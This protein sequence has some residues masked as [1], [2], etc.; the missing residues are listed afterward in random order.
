MSAA[1]ESTL[2]EL[3]Q[4]AAANNA[5]MAKLT[6]LI[7][8]LGPKLG[9]ANAGVG[10]SASGLIAAFNPLSLVVKGITGTFNILSNLLGSLGNIIGSTVGSFQKF[11]AMTTTGTMK[12]S[13]LSKIIGD[14]VT[15][16]PVF[17]SI[18]GSVVGVFT[19]LIQYSEQLLV[20]YRN[21]SDVGASFGGNLFEMAQTAYNS[22]LTLDEF[23]NIIKQNS[24]ILTAIGPG[25]DAGFRKFGEINRLLIGPGSP[26]SRAILSLGV[27]ASES[28]EMLATYINIHGSLNRES[29]R[30]NNVVAASVSNMIKEID[31][32]AK[33]TGQSRKD[34]EK[35]LASESLNSQFKM[36]LR[37]LD[38]QQVDTAML[39]VSKALQIGGQGAADALKQYIMTGGNSL[40]VVT[41]DMKNLV[42]Q[43]NGEL[44]NW[45][46]TVGDASLNMQLSSE[47]RMRQTTEADARLSK[48]YS[49]FLDSFGQ[50][51][52]IYY[53]MNESF[54]KNAALANTYMQFGS[55]SEKEREE[56]RKRAFKEQQEQ[57][58]QESEAA[59]LAEIE[60]K[61]KNIG[62]SIMG[63]FLPLLQPI[64]NQLL[65]LGH[66]LTNIIERI[67]GSGGIQEMITKVTTWFT[68]LFTDLTNAKGF[69]GVVTVLK[70]R[71]TQ[72][73]T[74]MWSVIKPGLEIIW[75]D[76]KPGLFKLFQEI[77]DM[78]KGYLFGPKLTSADV[79]QDREN[80]K[81]MNPLQ[82]IET[83]LA[84]AAENIMRLG[85][86]LNLIDKNTVDRI[87]AGRITRE[88]QAVLPQ[89]A[90]RGGVEGRQSG[91]LGVTG[92][93][94][95]NF[96]SGTPVTLHG[97]EAVVTPS[98]MNDIINQTAQAAA[99]SSNKDM[100][101]LT[102]KVNEL[103]QLTSQM[104]YYLKQTAEN[105]RKNVQATRSIGGDILAF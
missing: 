97:T 54:I 65:K 74:D 43:T 53:Q 22:M 60:R 3:L 89:Y 34:A 9:T 31:L 85:S 23:Q 87:V 48:S 86:F 100:S 19:N 7:G 36:F 44:F 61:L 16:V 47:E 75:A 29:L 81:V 90:I 59:N 78:I 49:S 11:L 70:D 28:A 55:K 14:L 40:A 66:G 72:L 63:I 69:E 51:G 102:T 56:L 76:I 80:I 62:L 2:Q 5:N 27:T 25:L 6:S 42:V 8:Q 20:V 30:N 21:I 33:I 32:W 12:F 35:A 71:A 88:T 39:Q 58:K 10:S 98:Q 99:A 104:L 67:A 96:G 24:T 18:L 64:S 52:S 46:K 4:I 37:H 50:T 38:P 26:Y 93:Y 57:M 13:D 91:S 1:T 77:I 92:S 68:T 84:R 95:E 83:S 17:G 15:S 45:V 94:F 105:T 82:I 79:S 103:S 41:E 101:S 73:I